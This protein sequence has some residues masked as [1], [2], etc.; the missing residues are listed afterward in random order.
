MPLLSVII[1]VYKVENYLR[2]CVDSVLSQDLSDIEVILVDDGSPD[3]CP[4]ICDAY[5][6]TDDRVVVIHKQNGGLS[7][8]RNAGIH[9]STGDYITFLDSDDKWNPNVS[10]S[11]V[12]NSVLEKPDVEVLFFNSINFFDGRSDTYQRLDN[13]LNTES[14]EF[15]D[16]YYDMAANGN[17]HE[18]ACTKIIKNSYVKEMKLFFQEGILGEDTE[19]IFRVYRCQPTILICKESLFMCRLGRPGSITNS[20]SPK[21]I[22]DLITVIKQS[23]EHYGRATAKSKSIGTI[24]LGHCATLWFIAL[25]TLPEIQDKE[26]RHELERQLLNTSEILDYRLSKKAEYSYVSY[27]ML[28]M[29]L[30]SRLLCLY[31]NKFRAKA[32][33]KRCENDGA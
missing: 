26:K 9:K 25:S 31:S 12:M 21:T 28:G 27:K 1:P 14:K 11:R 19:W 10:L 24:E 18:S 6:K 8:A 5:A 16:F 3:T 17:I 2:E 23:I 33:L 7:S 15:I 4:R 20:K 30:T 29:R 32:N 13:F 22:E